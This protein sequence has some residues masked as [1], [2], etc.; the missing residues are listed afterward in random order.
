VTHIYIKPSSNQCSLPHAKRPPH[1]RLRPNDV[2]GKVG[3]GRNLPDYAT[4]RR[5]VQYFF[6]RNLIQ[7]PARAYLARWSSSSDA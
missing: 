3:T 5:L 2:I 1:G 7:I 4:T 6:R